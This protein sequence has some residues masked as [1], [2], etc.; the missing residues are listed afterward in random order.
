MNLTIRKLSVFVFLA[1][2][3]LAASAV[4]DWDADDSH[5]MH[6]PQLPDLTTAGMDVLAGPLSVDDQG[7]VYYE[8]FLAD[9][10]LCTESGPITGIHIW[11]SYRSDIKYMD[12]PILSLV[13]YDNVPAGTGG[14]YYSRPGQALWNAYVQPTA[15]RIYATAEESFYD[16]PDA[17]VGNDTIVWQYN[18]EFGEDE[19]FQ[20]LRDRIY[21]L[22][23]K[24]TFDLSGDGLV[25]ILDLAQLKDYWPGSFGWKTSVVEQYEDAAVWTDVLTFGGAPHVVPTPAIWLPMDYPDVHEYAGQPIDLAFV[26]TGPEPVELDF[27]DAPRPYPTLQVVDGARHIIG[28]PYFCDWGGGDSPDP[29]GDGQPHMNALGDDNNGSDD[30][31]GVQIPPLT[32]GVASNI[33]LDVCG[34]SAPG[35][36]VEI[37]I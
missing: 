33:T 26:I 3:V 5:K 35:A 22:G 14:I 28:G 37:W 12:P 25:N 34:S 1:M 24:H 18:F 29:E 9:D 30:E 13:I 6:Y 11:C 32:V 2:M 19:A 7:N 21:W 15:E 4:G 20:Q 16:P 36:M 8:K 31:D 23:L 10:F 17:I 27:G